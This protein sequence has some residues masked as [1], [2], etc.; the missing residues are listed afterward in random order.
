[1]PD[2]EPFNGPLKDIGNDC[3]ES[4]RH[5]A[6]LQYVIPLP[7]VPLPEIQ[8]NQCFIVQFATQPLIGDASPW[9]NLA[10]PLKSNGSESRLLLPFGRSTRRP[11]SRCARPR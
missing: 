1:M 4:K 9:E 10:S 2:K 8:Y 6:S 7:D 5:I 11:V 3:Q